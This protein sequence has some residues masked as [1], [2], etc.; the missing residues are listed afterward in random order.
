MKIGAL[1]REH[2]RTVELMQQREQEMAEQL[3][4]LQHPKAMHESQTQTETDTEEHEE[5]MQEEWQKLR[6]SQKEQ[7]ALIQA[8]QAELAK[9]RE[10]QSKIQRKE[11]RS[12][13]LK[14]FSNSK[15]FPHCSK[16][17]HHPLS[18]WHFVKKRLAVLASLRSSVNSAR[19]ARSTN[20][21]AVQVFWSVVALAEWT[22]PC[23]R[24][25]HHPTNPGLLHRG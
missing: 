5:G 11:T 16:A 23:H 21:G 3:E 12:V 8:L 22:Q 18:N 15:L 7:E 17:W 2:E 25:C 20:I 19:S 10:G 13:R 1:N 4:K 14:P 6:H 9:E 24:N